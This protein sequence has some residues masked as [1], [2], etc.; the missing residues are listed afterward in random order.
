MTTKPARW[1]RGVISRAE[2]TQTYHFEDDSEPSVED[3]SLQEWARR[4]QLAHADVQISIACLAEIQ[5][6]LVHAQA[7]VVKAELFLERQQTGYCLA[8]A[9]LPGVPCL[10]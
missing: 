4:C 1:L 8:A 2:V 6:Q 7:S 5:N 10:K 9:K 3:F